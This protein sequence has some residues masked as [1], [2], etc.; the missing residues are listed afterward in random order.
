MKHI[1]ELK[2]LKL[3]MDE[4][5]ITSSGPMA[6]RGLRENKD[7]DIIVKPK[8]WEG[9]K[10]QFPI[11]NDDK[12]KVGNIEICQGS[13]GNSEE[14]IDNADV[15]DGFRFVKLNEVI[16]FKQAVGREKDLKDIKLIENFLK[17]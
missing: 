9:L 7:I 14:L 10:S 1:E 17:K 4:F 16:K 13:L 6:I 8:L 15:I 12:I 2:K 5:A 11:S 3:P